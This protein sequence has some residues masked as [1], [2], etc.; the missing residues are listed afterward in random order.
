MKTFKQFLNESQWMYHGT[1]EK[2]LK[3]LQP[4]R[5]ETMLDRAV[6]S[7]FAADPEVSKKFAKGL[8]RNDNGG[9]RLEGKVYK[10]KAPKRSKLETVNQH[11]YWRKTTDQGKK[12][13][14]RESDQ[15]AIGAHISATVF[16]QPEHKHLFKDWIKHSRGV[17]DEEA[18]HVHNSLSQGKPVKIHSDKFTAQSFHHL[19]RNYDS[20]L[21][22]TP[23]KGFREKVV[24]HFLDIMHKKGK[25]GMVYK[26][27]S[28]METEG[29]RSSKSYIMFHP[30]KLKI[31]PHEE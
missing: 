30:N 28:P 25:E 17:S 3:E 8:Y 23:D 4:N 9:K 12:I 14:G 10:T 22:T 11:V 29:I 19:M 15:H 18:E 16:S 21:H 27:T 1:P 26:N 7:H 31:E 20:G 24:N 5:G 6:G 2:E 13:V